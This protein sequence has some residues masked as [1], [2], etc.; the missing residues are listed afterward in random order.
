MGCIEMVK[1]VFLCCLLLLMRVTGLATSIALQTETSLS[2]SIEQEVEEAIERGQRWFKRQG[3][4]SIKGIDGEAFEA[5]MFSSQ[6]IVVVSPETVAG[7]MATVDAVDARA[8][9]RYNAITAAL[10]KGTLET[11]QSLPSELYVY[12]QRVLMPRCVNATLQQ[13]GPPQWR[14]QLALYLV[15]SQ[16]MDAMGGFWQEGSREESFWA[17]LLL[18]LL[19]HR[20][21]ALLPSGEVIEGLGE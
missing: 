3:I 1:V 20:Q 18:R 12:V 9:S 5:L 6:P 19:I 15:T 2:L 10:N 16:R 4:T 17:V 13:E 21:P 14:T 11:L 8:Q 7:C